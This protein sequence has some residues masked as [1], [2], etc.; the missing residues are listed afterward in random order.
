MRCA[1]V[2]ERLS[3]YLDR[4][5]E[6]ALEQ[7]VREH[8]HGCVRCRQELADLRAI[9]AE[10]QALPQ[11]GMGA[12]FAETVTARVCKDFLAR[13]GSPVARTGPF[14]KLASLLEALVELLEAPGSPR[15][16]TLDEFSDF[17]PLSLGYVYCRLLGL[18]TGD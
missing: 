8:L 5:L 4:E 18:C 3:A 7:P 12:E 10:I 11:V 17:P 9:D 13:D 1:D 15:T 16:R 14:G 2:R 6:P